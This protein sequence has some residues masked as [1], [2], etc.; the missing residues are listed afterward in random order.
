VETSGSKYARRAYKVRKSK[1]A[2]NGATAHA[3]I[4]QNSRPAA[5]VV[6]QGAATAA[7][8]AALKP[9]TIRHGVT[10]PLDMME[11]LPDTYGGLDM[12]HVEQLYRRLQAGDTLA[13]ITVATVVAVDGS[14]HF[15]VVD[16]YHRVAAAKR[17][18]S[19]QV[20]GDCYIGLSAAEAAVK[21][22]R[23]NW[24]RLKA[25]PLGILL[26]VRHY[27]KDSRS[28][29]E[30]A[31]ELGVKP[32]YVYQCRKVIE[33][34]PPSLLAA[35]VGDPEKY[36]WRMVREVA[37]RVAS[38][39]IPVTE[40]NALAVLTD[41]MATITAEKES[42]KAHGESGAEKLA[43]PAKPPG[44]EVAGG[45]SPDTGP[46]YW[47][48]VLAGAG[49]SDTA[50]KAVVAALSAL[51]DTLGAKGVTK[52]EIRDAYLVVFRNSI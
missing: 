1:S 26:A 46:A 44:K 21:A 8:A 32:A 48:K 34:C 52:G 43:K 24:C 19:S 50:A 7:D 18:G 41:I 49:L 17:A 13:P 15:Y 30:I 2:V 31:S 47:A 27:A 22:M 28:V 40:K 38:G 9:G 16:G 5:T 45:L 14:Q 51:P 25:R 3:P 33:V 42:D 37:T 36:T 23:I 39:G 10:L 6:P 20:V 35:F 4:D 29:K 12:D 11:T